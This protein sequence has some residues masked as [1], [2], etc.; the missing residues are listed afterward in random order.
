[1]PFAPLEPMLQ[2][3]RMIKVFPHVPKGKVLV[4]VGCDQEHIFISL[5]RRRMSL[6][7]GLDIVVEPQKYA[8][9]TLLRQNLQK[10][11][12]LPNNS[13]DAI[14]MMAVLEHMKYPKDMVK[15][16]YR[17][18]RKDGV[19][20]VTVPSPKCEPLLEILA[21]LRLVRPDMIHQHENY[22]TPRSLKKICKDAGF[23]KVYV[24][25]FELG[26]NTFMRATK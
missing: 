21:K 26:Y 14:T 8:N 23:R 22:F 4:D 2:T 1:M 20:L 3:L 25:V 13:A 16:S 24:E 15:E 9:V 12:R 18:L 5:M 7:I 11:I 6:C 10:K 17:I 19:F